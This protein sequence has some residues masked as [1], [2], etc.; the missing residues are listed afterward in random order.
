MKYGYDQGVES[1][2]VITWIQ[3][4]VQLWSAADQDS[5]SKI[6][7]L[8]ELHTR[9]RLQQIAHPADALRVQAVDGLVEE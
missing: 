9:E 1:E 8:T 7:D 6:A 2:S 5:V 4:S 3:E